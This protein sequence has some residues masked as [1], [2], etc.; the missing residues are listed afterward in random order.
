VA[1]DAATIGG[2][3]A[4]IILFYVGGMA[5]N[6]AAD[7]R[8]DRIERPGRPI[9]SGR[10]S[11][12]AAY[13]FAGVC[14]FCGLLAVALVGSGALGLA[15]VLVVAIVAYDF[16]HTRFKAS[17]LVMGACRGLVYLVAAAGVAW[18]IDMG[19][20][21]W[22]AAALALY[23]VALTSVARSETHTRRGA[24]RLITLAM[25]VLVLLPVVRI[26]PE[27]LEWALPAGMLALGWL[28]IAARFAFMRPPRT[29]QAVLTLLSGICLVDAFFLTLLGR[30][31]LAT[32]AGVCFAVTA[33]GH[34]RILGT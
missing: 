13:V 7:V 30:P 3:S 11:L 4:A 16:L 32:L 8:V 9:P 6:D 26:R 23:T 28:A 19:L 18:P 33:W 24:G 10:V 29:I 21:G 20:A 1:L 31:V 2:S 27:S 12:E 15:L 25:P 34:R 5:L 14:L 22:F 17:V